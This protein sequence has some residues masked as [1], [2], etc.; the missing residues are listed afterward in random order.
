MTENKILSLKKE[1]DKKPIKTYE[2]KV[3]VFANGEMKVHTD[4]E[5][6]NHYEIMGFHQ[7]AS[8]K[9]MDGI[10]EKNG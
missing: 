3:E 10:K 2:F 9:I 7:Y 5:G 4:G 1:E 6:F 8:K